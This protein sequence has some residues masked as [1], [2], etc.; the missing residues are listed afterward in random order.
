MNVVCCQLEAD[1]S[2]SIL[3]G[4]SSECDRE[5]PS[6]VAMTQNRVQAPQEKYSVR[7]LEDVMSSVRH[8]LVMYQLVFV[9]C[10]SLV[11]CKGE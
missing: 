3:C 7:K 10:S 2:S 8:V 6:R 11:F 5:A 1:H 9:S 4:V